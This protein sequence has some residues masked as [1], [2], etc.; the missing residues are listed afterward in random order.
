MQQRR[1]N[2]NHVVPEAVGCV[3]L[4]QTEEKKLPHLLGFVRLFLADW[5]GVVIPGACTCGGAIVAPNRNG[6]LLGVWSLVGRIAFTGTLLHG[7]LRHVVFQCTR[8]GGSGNGHIFVGCRCG[9]H[10]VGEAHTESSVDSFRRGITM[11]S[12]N[13]S[14]MLRT[15]LETKTSSTSTRGMA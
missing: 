1:V 15:A 8:N 13:F 3:M 9:T 14:W 6:R 7:F 11:H 10:L 2:G 5:L 12:C 4:H